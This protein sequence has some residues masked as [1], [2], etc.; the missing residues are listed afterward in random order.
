MSSVR[1]SRAAGAPA[2]GRVLFVGAFVSSAAAG[3]RPIAEELEQRLPSLGWSARL[4]SRRRGRIERV[5]D[6]LWTTASRRRDYDVAHVDVFSGAAFAWAE[7]AALVL[8]AAGK[9]WVATLRGGA[10]PE[11][12]ARHAGRTRRLLARARGVAAPSRYLQRE[13]SRYR[14]D[15][16]IIPNA[17]DVARYPYRLRARPAPRLVWL[18]AFHAI[19][20]PADAPRVLARL[21]PEFPDARLTMIGPDTGD[22]SLDATRRAASE[23]G[24]GDR[25]E[26]V[27]GVPKSEVPGRLS[28]ADVFLNTTGID[29][30]P[31]SVLEALACGL[32]V[33][34]TSAGGLPDLVRDG[35]TGLL[36][37]ADDPEALATAVRR[38]LAEPALAARLSANARRDAEAFDWANVLPMWTSFLSKAAMEQSE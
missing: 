14:S 11:F 33:V 13:M 7:A 3:R 15:V 16:R 10:L 26:I 4:T 21:A 12:A 8:G 31:V 6:L 22:G 18:R 38:V 29:N 24:V 9:P 20:R 19:Y 36:A 32:C 1:A 25:L 35:E 34:T 27:P 23:L 2:V 28:R 37:P 17:I 30:V 5:A